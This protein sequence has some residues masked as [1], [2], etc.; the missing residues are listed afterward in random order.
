MPQSG[1][2]PSYSG[3]G[4]LITLIM[5]RCNTCTCV[6][7]ALYKWKRALILCL[8]ANVYDM[9]YVDCMLI[10]ILPNVADKLFMLCAIY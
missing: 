5:R 6:C 8:I 2:L 1:F 7:T 9:L 4:F 3:L 10:K